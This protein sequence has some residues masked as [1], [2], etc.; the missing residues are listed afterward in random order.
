VAGL[1]LLHTNECTV[2]QGVPGGMWSDFGRM[3]LKL[4]YVDLTQNTYI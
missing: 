1:N 4:K 2:I 3:F